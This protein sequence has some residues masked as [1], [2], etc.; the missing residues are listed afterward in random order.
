VNEKNKTLAELWDG[1]SL[2]CTFHRCVDIRLYNMWEQEVSLVS[3]I[4]LGEGDELVCQFSSSGIYSA[5]SLYSVINFRG[6]PVYF[7]VV[8]KLTIP[9]RVHIFLWLL[10]KNNLI[11]RDNL[12]KRRTLNDASCL[13]CIEEESVDHLFFGCVV[14]KRAWE[15][16]SDA[17]GV[18][19]GSDYVSIAKLC[20]CNKKFG[21]VNMVSAA[22][23]W[24][25]WK[26]R[27]SVF[28]GGCLGQFE[29]PMVEIDSNAEVLKNP[30]PS[31]PD[32][33]VRSCSGI[34]KEDGDA[35]RGDLSSP[36]AIFSW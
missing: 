21:I 20:L 7:P 30:Y 12:G 2:K 13:F 33:W 26:L 31:A 36:A 23:C 19:V 11:T 35:A 17:L 9:P 4:S 22:L 34:A 5:H 18:N 24:S 15:L 14:A 28:P 25:L 29:G 16:V 3:T 27:N 6:F 8:W 32:G 1:L 10:S